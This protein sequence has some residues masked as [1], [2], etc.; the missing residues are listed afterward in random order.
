M[1]HSTLCARALLDT[2]IRDENNRFFVDQFGRCLNSYTLAD[3]SMLLQRL[4][5]RLTLCIEPRPL[6]VADV[7]P[8]IRELFIYGAKINDVKFFYA[9]EEPQLRKYFSVSKPYKIPLA[10][11]SLSCKLARELAQMSKTVEQLTARTVIELSRTHGISVFRIMRE[12][13]GEA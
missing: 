1:L 8:E 12:I 4:E 13:V 3:Y 11:K 6:D 5:S 10:N 2:A 9:I 7:P